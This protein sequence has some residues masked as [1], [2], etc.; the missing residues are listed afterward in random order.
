MRGVSF[1]METE[2]S[3][4]LKRFGFALFARVPLS[5]KAKGSVGGK[6]VVLSYTGR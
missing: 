1:V 6:I 2:G 5:M 4:V 3:F